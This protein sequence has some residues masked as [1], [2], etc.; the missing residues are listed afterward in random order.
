[1]VG[2]T[3]SLGKTTTALL[4]AAVLNVQK[5]GVA[6][7][8]TLAHSDSV[9]SI[10]AEQSTP[11][12]DL[13]ANLLSS[14]VEQGCSH[15][16]VELSSTAL[17]EQRAAGLRLETGVITNIRRH[18]LDRHTSFAAYRALKERM[19]HYL[20][21]DAPL[22]LNAD[23][24]FSRQ[25]RER[26]ARPV[27]SFGLHNEAD[28]TA[29]V[30]ERVASEQTFLL[31]AGADSILVRTALIGDQHISNCLAATSVGLLAG[32]E[33]P[34][35]AAALESVSLIP[36]RMERI[37]CG[38]EFSVFVDEGRSPDSLATC[39]KNVRS[40][41]RGRVL[42]VASPDEELDPADYPLLGKVLEKG[43]HLRVITGA[44]REQEDPLLRS[45]D[46]LDGFERPGR[47]HVI[48]SREKAIRWALEEARPG[49]AVVL[50]GQGHRAW[51]CLGQRTDD[52]TVARECLY[53]LAARELRGRPL[54]FAYHG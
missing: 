29:T 24:P 48:P 35:I 1:V 25:L 30:L 10:A 46:V 11:R 47:A 9:R 51:Y 5:Q 2:V 7:C 43:A 28:V 50:C 22:V 18:H 15:A 34:E 8:S 45:H 4:I 31:E 37:E 23:D 16:V 33:L 41:T 21:D 40:V 54:V 20:A 14:A 49:D 27:L 6:V 32:L 26:I 38:Q 53:S 17:A 13:L 42:C 19:L 3:G 52:A 44:A 12:A 36:G 39:L